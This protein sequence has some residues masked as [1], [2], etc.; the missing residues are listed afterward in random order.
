MIDLK[1]ITSLRRPN[2]TSLLGLALDGNRLEGVWLKRTNGSLHVQA[3][4]SVMLTLDLLTNAPELVGR[5]I[6]NHLDAA[7]I[8]ERRCVVALPH[9]W[10][11]A[12]QAPLPALSEADIAGFL[13]LEA[14]R[15]F[16]CD[17]ATLMT[18]TSRV[19]LVSGAQYAL[20]TG[21][22]RQQVTTV[23][24][25]LRA[26]QLKPESFALCITA[27]EAPAEAGVLALAIGESNVGLQ[28]S[29]G[30]G[31]VALR[32]LES[33]IA[34]EAGKRTLNTALVAREVRITLGQLPAEVR[35]AVKQ[36]RVFGPRDLAHQLA[37]EL[38]LRFESLEVEVEAVSSYAPNQFGVALPANAPVS[39][40][41][42]VAA[43]SLAGRAPHLEF[44]PPKVSRL[45]EFTARY[46][47][48]KLRKAGM[49]AVAVLLLV[50]GAFGFQ[51][52]QLWRLDSRW[53]AMATRVGELE[54]MQTNIKTY[55]PWFDESLRSLSILK[56]LTT[57]FPEDGMVTAKTV[58]IRN[59]NLVTC[60]GTA[61]DNAAL[62]R[63]LERLRAAGNVADLKVNRLQGKS[64]TMQFTFDFH[65][66]DGGG[67]AN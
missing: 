46:G 31:V 32:S 28:V 36:I 29:V 24:A 18:A 15:S 6:R 12:V 41:C 10:V 44:L 7:E 48:G 53:S 34:N 14:E 62:L 27:L 11:L 58:E 67:H 5:E 33:A 35:S 22:T 66:V 56:Q 45:Q 16:P 3:S 9:K 51:Q 13:Q 63:T 65:W 21:I 37:D 40:A 23:E 20:F 59:A 55:R 52:F 60:S 57:A 25:V 1:N 43:N 26:A 30:G 4:F 8:R 38:E 19:R 47:T 64:P 17:V 39:A 2:P 50:V 61:K 49:A 54:K 42:S